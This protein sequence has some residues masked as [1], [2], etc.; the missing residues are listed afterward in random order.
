MYQFDYLI[1]GPGAMGLYVAANLYNAGLQTAILD[2]KPERA[3]ILNDSGINLISAEGTT[4]TVP[5]PVTCNPEIVTQSRTIIII[6]K[7]YST[8]DAGKLIEP[9]INDLSLIHI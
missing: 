7:S 3:A 2:Y 6:T 8:S 4:I 9:F 1:V 5:I